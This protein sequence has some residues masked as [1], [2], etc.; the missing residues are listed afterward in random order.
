M[1]ISILCS[2]FNHPIYTR[3]KCWKEEHGKEHDVELVDKK[4]NLN[5]GDIL[6]LV[7]CHEI[8]GAE[9]RD[10]YRS[11]LVIHASDLPKGRGWSPHVWQ[12]LEGKN[13]I[14]VTLLEAEDKIDS[15]SIWA[16]K[17]LTLEGH[18]LYDEI[19]QALFD[20][21]IE[22]MD[23]ALTNVYD[24]RPRSQANKGATYF[25]RRTPDD[26]RLDPFR[27]L[28]EQFDLLRVCDATRYPAFFEL[29]GHRYIIR[30]EKINEKA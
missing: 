18:E 13:A 12:I 5:G 25:P 29:R 9:T 27:T 15:G 17:K 6:F 8:I 30:L 14:T 2:D 4:A 11:S 1:K 28:A 3:L 10:R 26:S 16:T 7:S 19:N 20:T 21:E 23:Y 24:V 22:L